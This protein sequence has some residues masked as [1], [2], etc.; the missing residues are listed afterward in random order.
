MSEDLFKETREHISNLSEDYEHYPSNI[1]NSEAILLDNLFDS[2]DMILCTLEDRRDFS[3]RNDSLSSKEMECRVRTFNEAITIV[4]ERK[5]KLSEI[6]RFDKY[7]PIK[8]HLCKFVKSK[9]I[10]PY[11]V[12]KENKLYTV[13]ECEICGAYKTTYKDLKQGD[14]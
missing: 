6:K 4:K 13:Y 3:I 2:L 14:K 10:Q 11:T 7:I 8:P 12:E 9:K 1:T 5:R